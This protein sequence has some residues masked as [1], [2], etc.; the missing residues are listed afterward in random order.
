LGKEQTTHDRKVRQLSRE[1]KKKGY[2]V[3]ADIGG[4]ERPEPIGKYGYRPD[5]IATKRG[6]MKIIEVET[7]K[8]LTADREQRKA[9][10]KS[11]A[12]R[13]RANFDIV[14]TKP[15]EVRRKRD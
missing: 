13:K 10:I 7:P 14:V 5:I 11:V 4:Y 12:Q 6:V 1:L 15:R 9:F 3:K 8:S 2:N